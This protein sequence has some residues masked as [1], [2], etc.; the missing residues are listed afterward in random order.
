MSPSFFALIERFRH[1]FA[2]KQ[3][4]SAPEKA[5]LLLRRRE[6]VN[7]PADQR[8][9]ERHRHV[10][11]RKQP[12]PQKQN[13]GD[14]QRRHEHN[15][16]RDCRLPGCGYARYHCDCASRGDHQCRDSGPLRD[17]P[18][19]V[20][21]QQRPNRI[22][23][24]FDSG[25]LPFRTPEEGVKGCVVT[26]IIVIRTEEDGLA[27]HPLFQPGAIAGSGRRYEIV[28]RNHGKSAWR[29]GEIDGEIAVIAQRDPPSA[30]QQLAVPKLRILA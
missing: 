1:V 15:Q 24:N 22:R 19:E 16:S 17:R 7:N 2:Y 29:T 12:S 8:K 28:Q 14:N 27:F 18:Q 9:R 13:V 25:S 30:E 3:R 5:A 23:V 11:A 20:A 4:Y 21:G 26:V 10:E 6:P